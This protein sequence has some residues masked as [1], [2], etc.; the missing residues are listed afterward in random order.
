MAEH[1]GTTIVPARPV[2][3]KDKASVEGTVGVLS[4][5]IVASLRNDKFF[6][7]QELN[8]AIRIKLDEFNSRPFQKR[9]GC[10]LSAFEEE[11]KAFLLPLPS[12]PYE[13][14]VWS[15]EKGQPDYL[16]TA[17][18]CRCS[19]PY[20]YIGRKVDIWTTE[21]CVEV[22]TTTRGSRPMRGF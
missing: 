1:Y 9:K 17:G 18:G 4:T 15:S 13:T 7:F 3:P 16:V 11:E 10:R 12:T 6:S 2:S 14:A 8:E 20:E 19:I 21:K 22:F 5:W